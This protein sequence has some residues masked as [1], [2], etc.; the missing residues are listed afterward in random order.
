MLWPLIG[1]LVG[2]IANLRWVD[3]QAAAR[4]IR[5]LSE[6]YGL[7]INPDAVIENLAVGVQQRVEIVKALYRDASILILD[8][9]T[10]VLTPQ[11]A[12]DLFEVMRRLTDQ[13]VVMLAGRTLMPGLWSCHFHT[14]FSDW[15]QTPAPQLGLERSPAMMAL[16]AQKNV[17]TA[18][19]CGFTSLV[20]SSVPYNIDAAL[21]QGQG[22]LGALHLD[23]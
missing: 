8:E 9:P 13:G 1:V 5:A 21:H 22:A 10:A 11:E 6:E 17:Q 14:T 18:L 2:G 7:E 4:R 12:D 15:G 20:C 3:K 16:V 19:S 23:T